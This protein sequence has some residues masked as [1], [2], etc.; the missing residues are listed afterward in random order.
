MESLTAPVTNPL[1]LRIATMGRSHPPVVAAQI[2][3]MLYS[4]LIG[5]RKA[6]DILKIKTF[7]ASV[8]DRIAVVSCAQV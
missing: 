8:A 6:C 2:D 1:A 5:D 3:I 4:L 7:S